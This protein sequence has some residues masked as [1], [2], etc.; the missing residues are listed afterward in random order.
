[1]VVF[2]IFMLIM[3]LLIPGTMLLFG[4]R[5]QKKPPNKIN[6]AYGYRTRR[7]MASKK[8]WD[9]AHKY[10][11]R[12]WV[13]FGWFTAV[14]AVASMIVLAFVTSDIETVGTVGGIITFAEFI[15]LI[16]PLFFTERA[17]KQEFGI[18]F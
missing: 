10:C 13:K 7:S 2:Y 16:V 17:L 5:W 8:A 4:Y 12:I 9:F 3:T 18:K 6:S 14:F 11:G 15:P 1:M